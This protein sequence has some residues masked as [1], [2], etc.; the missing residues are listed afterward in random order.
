M[1]RIVLSEPREWLSVHKNASY[2]SFQNT[3]LIPLIIKLEMIGWKLRRISI[4]CFWTW[5]RSLN[6][7][8]NRRFL[9]DFLGMGIF[10]TSLL[11]HLEI[12]KSNEWKWTSR[13]DTIDLV[14]L[15][16]QVTSTNFFYTLC[17]FGNSSKAMLGSIGGN[18]FVEN[19]KK[20]RVSLYTSEESESVGSCNW[21]I[22]KVSSV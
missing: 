18:I 6:L 5:V 11:A 3:F 14:L 7:T 8:T 21:K 4:R 13:Y 22:V 10:L 20:L 19:D 16:L 2:R 17:V 9:G 15:Q 1:I 12:L